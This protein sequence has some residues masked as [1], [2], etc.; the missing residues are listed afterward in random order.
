KT[1]DLSWIV[2]GIFRYYL[3]FCF[4]HRLFN[5]GN[6]MSHHDHT[7]ESGKNKKTFASYL[8][9]FVL[10][11]ILTMIAFGLVETQFLTKTNLYIAL[12]AFALLQLFVQCTCFLRLNMG[13]EGQ[14]RLL[15][16]LFTLLIIVILSGGSLWIMYNLNYFMAH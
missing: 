15:P 6:L 11:I 3:D 9:G 16:F 10:C 7:F 4:Y 12:A 5:G 2:L 8:T 13:S 1:T 14:E